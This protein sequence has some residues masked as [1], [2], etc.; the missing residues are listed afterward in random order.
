V[1]SAYSKNLSK[2]IFTTGM[3][4]LQLAELSKH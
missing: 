1:Q 4:V 2:K 3:E